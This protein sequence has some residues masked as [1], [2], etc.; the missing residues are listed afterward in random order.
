MTATVSAERAMTI[1]R[2]VA[3]FKKGTARP[4]KAFQRMLGLLHMRLIQF[5]PKQRVPT[6]AWHHGRSDSRSVVSYINLQVSSRSD[7]AR[8][9]TT[10]FV[11]AQNNLC[12]LKATHV[13]GKINQRADML[14]RNNVSSEESTLHSLVVQKIWEVFGRARVDLFASED[15]SHCPIFFTKS[16]DTLSHEWPSLPLYAFPPVA[17]QGTKEQADSNSPPLEE[18]TLGVGTIPAAKSSPVANP[19]ET[20][21]PLSS[22]RHDMASTAWDMGPAC[23][24]ARREPFV[25]PK[26]VL[27]TMAEA[28][29]QS[30]RRLYGL[31][32]SIFSAWC[33]R[34]GHLQCVSGSFIPA[35]DA[36]ST[37]FLIH[38]QSLGGFPCPYC[39]RVRSFGFTWPTLFKPLLCLVCQ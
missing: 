34:P 15:N 3:S 26:H 8:W 10:F 30:T 32:W 20:G 13:P 27:N 35:G 18:P 28:R 1:Q 5:W 11:W 21:P 17:S 38:H 23:V 14:S 2:H 16:T 24:A 29:A 4:L 31:K 9:R 7:S 12:S 37:A 6:A 36:G 33:L 22:K 39:F 19:F 25:L